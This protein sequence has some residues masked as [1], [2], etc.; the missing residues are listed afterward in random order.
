VHPQIHFT[1][2]Q[3][4]QYLAF[5]ARVHAIE[6][7]ATVINNGNCKF[8]CV[9][10]LFLPLSTALFPRSICSAYL[11]EDLNTKIVRSKLKMAGL[12]IVSSFKVV[13]SLMSLWGIAS[14][15]CMHNVGAL[16]MLGKFSTRCHLK[17]LSFGTPSYWDMS[18]V[19]KA[20]RH[21]N[22]SDKCTRKV[23]GE[24]QS[25]LLGC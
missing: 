3:L 15:T 2:E 10:T 6:R 25:P 12:C 23:C 5:L 9:I 24:I 7:P 17:M 19:A 20:R 18:N 8:P 14:L 16:R 13:A 22:C 11:P 1:H 4:L 21:L